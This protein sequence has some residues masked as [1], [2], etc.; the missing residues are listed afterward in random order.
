MWC[1]IRD[2]TLELVCTFGGLCCLDNSRG[3]RFV[4]FGWLYVCVFMFA[5]I[6]F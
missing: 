3:V 1:Y 5:F 2:V 4:V 6:V